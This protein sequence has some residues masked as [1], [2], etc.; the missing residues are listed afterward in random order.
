MIVARLS[1]HVS[2]I[3]TC[4]NSITCVLQ[5]LNRSGWREP[6]A[7]RKP[8]NLYIMRHA[9]AGIP[10]ENPQLDLKRGL[11]KEGKE[12][13]MQMAR[14]LNAMRV[15]VDVILS[16]PLKRAT[17]T[18]QLVGTEMGYEAPI[19]ITQALAP[20]AEFGDFIEMLNGY[21]ECDGVLVVGHNPNLFRFIG[22]LVAG[23]KGAA[24]RIRKGSVTHINMATH[25]PRLQWLV[26]P[27]MARSIFS[28]LDR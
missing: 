10:R 23:Q 4:A 28:A 11:V 27:R 5:F 18:A 8:M 1:I 15:Q 13:C 25:P 2:S 21:A 3:G 19:E 7:P 12:Q 17:Q 9:N 22:R 14:L 24:I 16:S 20:E 6:E 26:D